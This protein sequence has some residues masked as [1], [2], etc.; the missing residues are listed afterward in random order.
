MYAIYE[1]CTVNGEIEIKWHNSI[2]QCLW[3]IW[4]FISVVVRPCYHLSVWRKGNQLNKKYFPAMTS[5]SPAHDLCISTLG[6]HVETNHTQNECLAFTNYKAIHETLYSILMRL[7]W[8]K[9][10]LSELWLSRLSIKWIDWKSSWILARNW[11]SS[12]PQVA[13]KYRIRDRTINLKRYSK[14]YMGKWKISEGID[15]ASKTYMWQ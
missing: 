1:Q 12:I 8:V 14:A 2:V 13:R 11:S 3:T 9:I 6:A 7:T 10:W 15:T 4:H 5:A